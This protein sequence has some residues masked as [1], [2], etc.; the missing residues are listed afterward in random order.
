MK[1]ISIHVLRAE[2]DGNADRVR[3]GHFISIHVLR[4]EDDELF[5]VIVDFQLDFNP[6]P[7]C[8]GRPESAPLGPPPLVFQSTSSVRRTTCTGVFNHLALFISIHV[9]RAEDD[10]RQTA[11]T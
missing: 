1:I 6:R 2:D 3:Q 10:P 9:L 8:G 7:P 11:R 5:R 4:A